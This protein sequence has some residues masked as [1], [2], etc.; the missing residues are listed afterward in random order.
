MQFTSELVLTGPEI[1]PFGPDT[2]V[3]SNAGRPRA[4]SMD[5]GSGQNDRPIFKRR[6]VADWHLLFVWAILW[7]CADTK[8]N[9]QNQLA[10]HANVFE[11]EL[12]E[13]R[14]GRSESSNGESSGAALYIY[15]TIDDLNVLLEPQDAI[16]NKKSSV[17]RASERGASEVL[18]PSLARNEWSFC[19]SSSDAEAICKL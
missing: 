5:H 6:A 17:Y 7:I 12:L 3:A 11:R 13:R 4:G 18:N 10:Y 16:G 8:D 15:G 1:V 2:K 19:F 14:H 9:L